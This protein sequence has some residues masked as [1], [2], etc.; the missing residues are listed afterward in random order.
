[1]L[2]CSEVGVTFC[3]Q[4]RSVEALRDLTFTAQRGE[5]LS[6][7]G[8]S[9]CGKTTLLRTLAGVL[10]PTRGRVEHVGDKRLVLVRQECSVFPWLTVLENT[11]FGLEAQGIGRAERERR[12]MPLL[13][14]FG[15]GGRERDYPKQ[16]STGMKQRVALVQ[17]FLSEPDVLLM[18]EPFAAL[19]CQ[20]RWQLQGELLELWEEQRDRTVILVTHD[21]EEA[22]RLS[23]RVLV[24]SHPPGGIVADVSVH[25]SRPRQVASLLTADFLAY[26]RTVLSKLGF[27]VEDL[28]YAAVQRP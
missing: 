15:L 11:T 17:A 14:R 2:R 21:V 5:L 26:K 27:A 24:L 1:M 10:Q 9:G 4:G 25:L 12:A 20:T 16:L 22:V 23:D 3:G 28:A 18:D 7:V 13:E 6:I 8:P 19:D